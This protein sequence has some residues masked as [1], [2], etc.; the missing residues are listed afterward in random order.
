MKTVENI[1]KRPVS[2]TGNRKG[3]PRPVAMFL[4]KALALF[5]VWKLL[6]ICYFEPKRTLDDPLTTA[7]GV[8]TTAALNASGGSDGYTVRKIADTASAD[9]GGT[10]GSS[11]QIY[12]NGGAT[13]K[14]ADPCNGLELMVLY[15]GFLIC[16]PGAVSR[17]W[18]FILGGWGLIMV[19]N[20]LRCMILVL[21]FVHSRRYL[22][23][24]HHFFFT[25]IVYAVI[26]LMW[27]LFS[28]QSAAAVSKHSGVSV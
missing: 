2:A 18:K 10:I 6:Y 22:D 21:I 27:Y 19:M 1:S 3:I 23:F 11:M 13:L 28:K 5:I 8:L 20:I 16:F 9:L 7:V 24:S 15:A 4:L 14:I 26:F 25:L 12:R 17:K